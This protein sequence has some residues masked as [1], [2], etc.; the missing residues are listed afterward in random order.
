[1]KIEGANIHIKVEENDYFFVQTH[2]E[3]KLEIILTSGNRM[4]IKMYGV[5]KRQWYSLCC[6]AQRL[7]LMEEG[8]KIEDFL[9]AATPI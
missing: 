6:Q 9:Q 1:M 7:L 8:E 2:G 5:N 3:D 4:P